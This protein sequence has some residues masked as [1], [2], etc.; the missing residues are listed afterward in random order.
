MNLKRGVRILTCDPISRL[1]EAE[2]RN[3]EVISVNAYNYTPIFRWPIPG[4][5]WMVREENGS[6]WLD[7]I[8]ELQGSPEEM[9]QAEPGDAI[10]STGSGRI[11]LNIG[12]QLS[13]GK[14]SG[15]RTVTVLPSFPVEGEEIDYQSTAMAEKGVRWRFR[16]NAKSFSPYKW[17]FVGGSQLRAGA[18]GAIETSSTV[19]VL[20]TG[21][22]S[23][24]VPL[25]GDYQI[26]LRLY[27]QNE[28][29]VLNEFHGEITGHGSVVSRV[30]RAVFDGGFEYGSDEISELSAG[31]VLTISVKNNSANKASYQAGTITIV[32]IRI[33]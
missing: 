25:A 16:Y 11:L 6:W 20:L 2:T 24:I 26:T 31:S 22:P 32:P 27:M 1:I 3:G 19:P 17:E 23:I 5:K 29:A 21:G 10:I 12:G 8:Y 28:E 14:V 15:I 9:I 4:E 13:E 33:G 18:A 7:G 30:G